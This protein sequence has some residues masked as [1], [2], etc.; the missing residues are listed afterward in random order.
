[1]A[2]SNRFATLWLSLHIGQRHLVPI[3]CINPILRS[4]VAQQG[5]MSLGV[6]LTTKSK[7][8]GRSKLRPAGGEGI[9]DVDP[10]LESIDLFAT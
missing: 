4:S 9:S 10:E 6:F 1:M 2:I 7:K 5:A 3:V 8:A